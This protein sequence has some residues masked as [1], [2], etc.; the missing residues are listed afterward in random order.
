LNLN[1]NSEGALELLFGISNVG[2]EKAFRLSDLGL[3]VEMVIDSSFHLADRHG[4]LGGAQ[5]K[6]QHR[7]RRIEAHEGF[8]MAKAELVGYNELQDLLRKF[9]ETE[10]VGDRGAVF[11][12]AL[13]HLFLGESEFAGEAL[14]G[15]GLL[16]GI[17]ILALE[18]LDDRD[19]HCLLVRDLADDGRDRG[20]ACLL[21]SAPSALT[22]DELV[23]SGDLAYGDW[24]H[25]A[26]NLDGLSEFVESGFV[27]V[28]PSL[29]GIAVNEFDGDL[30]HAVT[31]GLLGRLRSGDG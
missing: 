24:L 8:G 9:E 29:V 17:E 1:P 30:A 10:E 20:L 6:T 5:S 21:G 27:E 26:G 23:A 28:S 22:G 2:I 12:G 19:L 31:R 16:D 18:V 3:G 14:V 25:D 11:A 7:F 4:D 13:R 15:V